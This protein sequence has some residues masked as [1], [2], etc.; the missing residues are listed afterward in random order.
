[1]KKTI[2]LCDDQNSL[3]SLMKSLL[4]KNG[5]EVKT[6]GDGAEGVAL[7]RES[8]PAVLILDLAMPAL[9]GLGVLR[10]LKELDCPAPYTLVLTAQHDEAKRKQALELGAREVW[11]KP[12]NAADL[13]KHLQGL[14]PEAAA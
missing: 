8:R 5:F 6:A 9:D 13:I 1:V 4:V 14:A 11:T 7:V 10:K 3:V 12:F 2:V